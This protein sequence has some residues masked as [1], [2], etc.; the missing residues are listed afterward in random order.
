MRWIGAVVLALGGAACGP[1][2]VDSDPTTTSNTA[3]QCGAVTDHNIVIR[4]KVVDSGGAPVA[5][6]EIRLEE[7]FWHNPPKTWG[8]AATDATGVGEFTAVNVVAVADCWGVALNYVL[9]AQLGDRIGEDDYNSSLYDAII[10]E[11]F[12]TD[13]TS[14]PVVLPD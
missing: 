7:D 5:N 6:A 11:T 4:A 13:T 3:G 1:S 10:S 12:E 2:E 9:L 8:S 14:F